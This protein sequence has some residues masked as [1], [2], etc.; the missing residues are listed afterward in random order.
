MFLHNVYKKNQA[1]IEACFQLHQEGRILPDSYVIDLDTLLENARAMLKEAK[2]QGIDL[3]FMLKQLGRN[4]FIAKKLVALGYKGAVVVDFKEAKVM[5]K[6]QIPISNVGHLV[7]M[8]KAMIQEL[9]DYGCEYMSVFSLEKIRDIDACAAKSG[10]IQ[11][12]LLKVVGQK[13]HIYSGQ[14]AGFRIETLPTIIHEL[15]K[16][17]HVCIAGVTSF[18]CFL[19]DEKK[20][21]IKETENLATL[22]QAKKIFED[23]G[24]NIENI[25]APSATC[26]ATLKLMGK[27]GIQSAEPGHGLTGTTPYHAHKDCVEQP[28]TMYVSEVSHNFDGYGYCYGGGHYRRSHME[29]ALVGSSLSHAK[30]MHVTP[31]NVD[32][33]DYYFQLAHTCNVNDT[34][35]MSFRY[36]IFVTRSNVILLEGLHSNQSYTLRMYQSQ[37]DEIE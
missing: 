21:R 14:T 12:L 18:P 19:Y 16:L 25:N 36:Q 11:K 1:L 5:M 27:Y 26:T 31:P 20:N 9:V 35:L 3:Y 29:N 13:D 22:L 23:A 4:P 28:C 24:I 30:W 6:H 32:S 8:P 37:G 33:I 17:K 10:R 2:E 7:Q 15:K 34:V